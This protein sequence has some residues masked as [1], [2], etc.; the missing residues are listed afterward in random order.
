MKKP[1]IVVDASFWINCIYLNLDSY[2]F[3]YFTLKFTNKVKLEILF[4]KKHDFFKKSKDVL[5]FEK[6]LSLNK[7][8]I[9]DP[10][11]IYFTDLL[12]KK[13]GELYS[14]SLAKEKNYGI[15]IDDGV[16]YDVCSKNNVSCMNSIDFIIFLYIKK[17]INF[18]DAI[19]LINSLKFRVKEK[20]ILNAIK[21]IK[22]IK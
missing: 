9:K 16:P 21:Y 3:E 4:S 5:L 14:I 2:L 12:S 8:S 18:K 22:K 10:S 19:N 6:Y 20:Y 13:S 17:R 15:L 7:D 1:I 11:K